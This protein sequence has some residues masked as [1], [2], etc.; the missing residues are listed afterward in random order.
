MT[1]KLIS[2]VGLLLALSGPAFATDASQGVQAQTAPEP[3]AHSQQAPQ[4]QQALQSPQAPQHL[5]WQRVG[6]PLSQE[7]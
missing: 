7:S 6:S 4:S 3:Q 1:A 2:L 5:A